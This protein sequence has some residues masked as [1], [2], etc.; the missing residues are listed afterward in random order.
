[1]SDVIATLFVSPLVP[2]GKHI[3]A[4]MRF[5]PLALIALFIALPIASPAQTPPS[6]QPIV[7]VIPGAPSHP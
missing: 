5:E 3:V 1:V 2:Y 4:K 7:P 6:S